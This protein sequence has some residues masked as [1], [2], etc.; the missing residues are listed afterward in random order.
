MKDYWKSFTVVMEGRE[1]LGGNLRLRCDTNATTPKLW[2]YLVDRFAVSSLLD[3]GSGEG[4]APRRL[5][6]DGRHRPR[7]RRSCGERAQ[8]ETSGRRA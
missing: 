7:H 4:H 6:P 1:S 3:V 8:I 2:R 5:P